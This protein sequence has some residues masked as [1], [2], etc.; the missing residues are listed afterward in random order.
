MYSTRHQIIQ[1]IDNGAIAQDKIAHALIA[2]RVTPDAGSWKLFLDRLLLWLG[3]LA[4]AFSVMFFIAYNWTELGRFAKFGMVEVLMALAVG[5]YS[6][7]GKEKLGGKV[8]LLMATILLGVLLALYGQTY[9][10][11]AD[12]WQLFF[13]WGLLMLPWAVIARFAAIWMVWV[14]LMNISIALYF[15]TFRSSL[16]FIQDDVD[17][18]WLMFGF[19]TAV[20]VIWESSARRWEWL[21][22]RWA[23]RLIAVISGS[24]ITWLNL[25]VLIESGS[26]TIALTVWLA[27]LL[28]MY[29]A[30][31]KLSPDL[32]ML[33]GL[34]LSVITIAIFIMGRVLLDDFQ[35][36]G[37]F[38]LALIVIAMGAGSA[39]WLKRIH[40][41]MQ[42]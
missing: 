23:M 41:E 31:R 2:S 39:F 16:W 22:E 19:N 42:S 21:N 28:I 25:Y 14:A 29:R 20:Q 6:L 35:L 24:S 33:A 26:A 3:G 4:L 7:L 27:W 13:Y 37:L 15:D 11:G 36:G 8:L 34:C 9:Q 18:L 5:T 12:P 32:F 30:Y 38:V 1:L 17:L 10:T 40:S